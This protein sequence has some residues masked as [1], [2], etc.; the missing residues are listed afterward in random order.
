M[1]PSTSESREAYMGNERDQLFIQNMKG[2][3]NE[4]DERKRLFPTCRVA[5]W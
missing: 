5:E 4:Y 1:V 3:S 2:R